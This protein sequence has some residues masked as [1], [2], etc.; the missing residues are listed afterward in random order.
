MLLE[1]L[2]LEYDFELEVIDIYE[3]ESFLEKYHMIIPVVKIGEAEC[4]GE[5]LTYQQLEAA[6]R[7][8]IKGQEN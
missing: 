7:S 5:S 4:F 8:K 3:D 2:S 1:L 6:L